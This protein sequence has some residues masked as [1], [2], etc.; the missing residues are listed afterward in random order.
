MATVLMAFETTLVSVLMGT[1]EETVMKK[2]RINSCMH[3]V[4]H[5]VSA[6]YTA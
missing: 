6:M 5:F 2:V 1:L 3:I 4:K